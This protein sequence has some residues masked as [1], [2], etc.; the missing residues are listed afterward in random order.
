[1]EQKSTVFG[2]DWTNYNELENLANNRSGGPF[3]SQAIIIK[4][5]EFFASGH[6]AANSQHSPDQIR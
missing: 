5:P 1:M 2:T 4:F 6:F 3:S